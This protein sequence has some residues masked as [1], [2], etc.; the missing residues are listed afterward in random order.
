MVEAT[1]DSVIAASFANEMALSALRAC[2][3]WHRV[4]DR[5]T[6]SLIGARTLLPSSYLTT[7]FSAAWFSNSS[8][9][10]TAMVCSPGVTSERSRE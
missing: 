2:L 7:T 9:T 8:C 1:S 3:L 5:N 4:N 6:R 10:R